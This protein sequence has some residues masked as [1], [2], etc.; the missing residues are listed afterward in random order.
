VIDKIIP[1]FFV[2]SFV[3]SFSAFTARNAM[4][5]S[6]ASRHHSPVEACQRGNLSAAHPNGRFRP[7]VG[8]IVCSVSMAWLAGH[9]EAPAKGGFIFDRGF[10][11][12]G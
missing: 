3:S 5:S 2:Y 7:M 10:P 9:K 1:A 8:C 12:K 6:G 4:M 11:T